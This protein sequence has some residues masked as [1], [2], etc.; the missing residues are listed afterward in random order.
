MDHPFGSKQKTL[1]WRHNEHDC[2]SNHRR[3]DC[4]LNCLFMR[5]S[6]KTPKLRVTCLCAGNSPVTGEFLHKWPVTR[7]MFPLMTSPWVYTELPCFPYHSPCNQITYIYCISNNITTVFTHPLFNS[8]MVTAKH[9]LCFVHK[10]KN[11]ILMTLYYFPKF[12]LNF[13]YNVISKLEEYA[14]FC[15]R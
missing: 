8:H 6:K 11:N 12:T 9:F 10:R 13:T 15:G 14:Y 5:R 3:L 7:K 2:V 4:L 1:Q